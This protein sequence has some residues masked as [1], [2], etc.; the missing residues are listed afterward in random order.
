MLPQGLEIMGFGT[1]EPGKYMN[2]DKKTDVKT[3]PFRQR[4]CNKSKCALWND[5]KRGVAC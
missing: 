5:E 4:N 1:L 3:C 2:D